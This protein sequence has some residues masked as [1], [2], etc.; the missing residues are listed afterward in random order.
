M[1]TIFIDRKNSEL[2]VDRGR[3]IVKIPDIR[4]HFSMPTN[5]I[6]MVVISASVHFSSTLM[7]QLTADKI[8]VLFIN[9]RRMEGNTLTTGMMHNDAQRRLKQYQLLSDENIRLF[10]AK[11]LMMH[12]IILQKIFLKKALNKRLDC[13]LYLTR[14]L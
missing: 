10:Y 7:T 3:L 11:K 4:Q 8:V 5:I 6:E 9:P 12:K 13:R 1:K 14:A 2:E